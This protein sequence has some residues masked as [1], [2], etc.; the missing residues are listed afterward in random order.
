[1]LAHSF[2]V[3]FITFSQRTLPQLNAELTWLS[4]P[5]LAVLKESD[6][7]NDHNVTTFNKTTKSLHLYKLKELITPKEMLFVI[8]FEKYFIYHCPSSK[9]NCIHSQE[10]C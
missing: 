4:T 10:R 3:V 2:I 9:Q 7:L 8:C 6:D 1:M 5:L